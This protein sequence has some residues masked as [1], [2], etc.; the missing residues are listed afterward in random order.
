V[1]LACYSVGHPLGGAN[2]L[3]EYEAVEVDSILEALPTKL[4][5]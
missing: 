5:F 1:K 2:L 4:F 3:G